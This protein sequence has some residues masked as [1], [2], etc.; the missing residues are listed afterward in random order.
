MVRFYLG[1]GGGGLV[2][3]LFLLKSNSVIRGTVVSIF[4]SL[5]VAPDYAI[6]NGI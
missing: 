2:I 5:P 4:F 6:V 3:A 1:A